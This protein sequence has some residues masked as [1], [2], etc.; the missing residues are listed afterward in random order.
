MGDQAFA[1]GDYPND[2]VERFPFIE[3]Y[4]HTGN[5]ARALELSR[6]AQI[7]S[8]VV[9][10]PM[11]CRLWQRIERET[12]AW[13]GARLRRSRLLRLSWMCWAKQ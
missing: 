10:Q 1:S 3:G 8:P 6:E 4:A 9:M 5:W 12:H 13:R 11:L 2:P 7:I